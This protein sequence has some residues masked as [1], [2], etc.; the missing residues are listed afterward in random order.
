MSPKHLH[1]DPWPESQRPVKPRWSKH[2][3]ENAPPP[4]R[5]RLDFLPDAMPMRHYVPGTAKALMS[6]EPTGRAR[7][8]VEEVNA[9]RS[10]RSHVSLD[11]NGDPA[12]IEPGRG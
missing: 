2:R 9:P 7:H 10:A 8:A 11:P 5:R 6:G 1:P 12:D 4:G 3:A